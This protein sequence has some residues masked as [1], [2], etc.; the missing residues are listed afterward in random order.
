L[1]DGQV[2]SHTGVWVEIPAWMNVRSFWTDLTTETSG[3]PK[4]DI[5]VSNAATKPSDATDDAVVR[6]LTP[7]ANTGAGIE[8]YRW[9]KAKKTAGGTPVATMCIVEASRSS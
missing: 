4:V 3:T 5:M 2:A 6:S 8:S 9:V 1:L 7:A